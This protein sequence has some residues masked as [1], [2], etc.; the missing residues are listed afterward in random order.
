LGFGRIDILNA[1]AVIASNICHYCGAKSA[2]LECAVKSCRR[3]FHLVCGH[4]AKCQFDFSNYVSYCPE[5][6]TLRRPEDWPIESI[7]ATVCFICYSPIETYNP[8]EHFLPPCCEFGWLHRRCLQEWANSSGY[9]FH[10]P[11]CSDGDKQLFRA[12]AKQ[13]GLFIWDRDASWEFD[14]RYKDI[15]KTKCSAEHCR[16]RSKRGSRMDFLKCYACGLKV[17]HAQCFG[18]AKED[19]DNYTCEKCIDQSFLDIIPPPDELDLT[20]LGNKN[21]K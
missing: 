13:S 10:C 17:G 18:V 1:R 8:V 7:E 19:V 14:G 5:H 20:E 4:T 12:T 15:D 9:T 6:V 16:M 3:Q 21:T 11:Y 2:N